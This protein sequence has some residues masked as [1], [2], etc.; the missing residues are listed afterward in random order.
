MEVHE[1][2][3]AGLETWNK[4]PSS[5]SEENMG[6]SSEMDVRLIRVIHDTLTVPTLFYLGHD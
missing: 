2:N 6:G 1:E 5:D 4:V 3:D